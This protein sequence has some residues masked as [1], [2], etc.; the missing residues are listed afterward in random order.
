MVTDGLVGSVNELH[1]GDR[2]ETLAVPARNASRD[3]WAAFLAD[4]ATRAQNDSEAA[5]LA[6]TADDARADLIAK[7]EQ[8]VVGQQPAEDGDADG[9]SGPA[10][11]ND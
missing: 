9:S 2:I 3:E 7:Y 5:S 1:L 11:V 8:W 6:F 10:P 4:L